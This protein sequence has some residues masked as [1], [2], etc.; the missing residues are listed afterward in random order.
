[1]P[2]SGLPVHMSYD[3]VFTLDSCIQFFPVSLLHSANRKDN[4]SFNKKLLNILIFFLIVQCMSQTLFATHYSN[5]AQKL[6][7]LGFSWAFL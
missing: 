1:M 6:E 7:L 5:P 4:T 2:E 3:K